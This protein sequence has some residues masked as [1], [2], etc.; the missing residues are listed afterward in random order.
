MKKFQLHSSTA[1]TSGNI[2]T[3]RI[4]EIWKGL[5][6]W[7]DCCSL[8]L[9]GLDGN[10]LTQRAALEVWPSNARDRGL[11][12]VQSLARSVAPFRA[13]P[14]RVGDWDCAIFNCKGKHPY[15][16]PVLPVRGYW[17]RLEPAMAVEMQYLYFAFPSENRPRL[18]WLTADMNEVGLPVATNHL[19]KSQSH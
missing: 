5:D 18:N 16:N 4:A 12:S 7:T 8:I 11:F 14:L 6:G 17:Q 2:H 15:H 13:G 9:R 3:L 1:E 10:G 19:V